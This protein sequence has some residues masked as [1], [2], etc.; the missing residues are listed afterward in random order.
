MKLILSRLYLPEATLGVLDVGVLRLWTLEDVMHNGGLGVDSCVPPGEYMLEPHSTEAHPGTWALVGREV[1]HYPAGRARSTIL[2][3]TGNTSADT[4]GCILVGM[5]AEL[6]PP[7]HLLQ[8]RVAMERL[9][10]ELAI[11]ESTLTI[12]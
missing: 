7:A 1:S 11:G 6:G 10:R 3:H 4:L 8:S 9:K 12:R 2:I 5:G